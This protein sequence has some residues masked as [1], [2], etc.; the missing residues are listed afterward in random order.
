MHRACRATR[1]GA[2]PAIR[3]SSMSP[4][5]ESEAERAPELQSE[6]PGE[7]PG[8]VLGRYRL[9]ERIGEGGMGTV[10]R[11][12]QTEPVR[13]TVAVKVIKL[14]LDTR[15]VVQRFEAGMRL[16][17]HYR[18]PACTGI[19]DSGDV[20]VDRYLR[21]VEI[22]LAELEGPRRLIATNGIL[23]LGDLLCS[24]AAELDPASAARARALL[25]A[26]RTLV[27]ALAERG[28]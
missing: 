28:S 5:M 14:G 20:D 11:A 3:W 15:E 7:Q 22:L 12:E 25:L 9:V 1:R 27:D 16:Y 17:F 2:A 21:L 23:K 26:E 4:R 18:A 24:R 13:R 8:D 10:W 6:L 19:V